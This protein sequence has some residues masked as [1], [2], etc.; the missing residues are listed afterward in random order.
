MPLFHSWGQIIQNNNKEPE[1]H[2]LL[3]QFRLKLVLEAKHK[4]IISPRKF[5]SYSLEEQILV[6]K[7]LYEKA[8][9][10]LKNE[11]E[12]LPLKDLSKKILHVSIG[13]HTDFLENSMDEISSV[14]HLHYYS[15]T[16]AASGLKSKISNYDI[17]ITSVHC[18]SVRPKSSYGLPKGMNEY[19]SIIPNLS[20]YHSLPD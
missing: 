12:V 9:T 15:G 18:N 2:A 17:V 1:E 20:P 6:R 10:V 3:R 19:L 7:Q 16:E 8:I 5:K 11:S 14:K 13:A 4:A